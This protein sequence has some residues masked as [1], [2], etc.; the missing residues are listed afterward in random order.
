MKIVAQSKDTYD[1]YELELNNKEVRGKLYNPK[2]VVVLGSYET[3]KRA[4]DVYS[5]IVCISWNKEAN[6]YVMPEA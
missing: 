2:M 5:E 4:C 6:L 1:V 3:F